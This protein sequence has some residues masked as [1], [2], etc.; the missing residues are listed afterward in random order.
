MGRPRPENRNC[1]TFGKMIFY[2]H[3]CYDCERDYIG[4]K[5]LESC[6]WC[7]GSNV[8]NCFRERIMIYVASSWRNTY[9][10]DVVRKLREWG[11]QVYDFHHPHGDDNGFD[12]SD[13]AMNGNWRNWDLAKFLLALEHPKAIEGFNSNMMGILKSNACVLVLPSGRCAHLEAGFI[14]GR[15]KRLFIYSPEKCEPDLMYKMAM[16]SSNLEDAKEFLMNCLVE[17]MPARVE[18]ANCDFKQ[19][20]E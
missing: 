19:K 5:R 17:D 2:P 9:Q 11:F 6:C 12:F 10:P 8:I 1:Q 14:R 3:Y 13:V 15:G 7:G 16:V 20:G 4:S 18:V